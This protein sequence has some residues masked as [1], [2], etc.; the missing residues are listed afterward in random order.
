MKSRRMSVA[1]FAS[2]VLASCGSSAS[3]D[4][5]VPSSDSAPITSDATTTT[6]GKGSDPD[7]DFCI[8]ARDATNTMSL[9]LSSSTVDLDTKTAWTSVVSL[10]EVV[11]KKAPDDIH[12]AAIKINEGL[13]EY[14]KV[15]AKYD[16]D[17][18]KITADTEASA[19]L[20]RINADP[21]FTA[22]GN[23]LDKYFNDV[24][25]IASGS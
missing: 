7:S 13:A 3:S 14:T 23:Q 24:C 15:L 1:V 17:F 20:A 6:T 22:A 5:T 12:D 8:S 4:T 11:A 10:F 9:A 21:E 25:G 16:Y 18:A 19:D 2:F